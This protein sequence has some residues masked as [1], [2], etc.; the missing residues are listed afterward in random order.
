MKLPTTSIIPVLRVCRGR[1]MCGSGLAAGHRHLQRGA[2]Q[3][4]HGKG[5]ASETRRAF[6]LNVDQMLNDS[7]KNISSSEVEGEAIQPKM[8]T[9]LPYHVSGAAPA[10]GSL[11]PIR[12]VSTT[13]PMAPARSGR[14]ITKAQRDTT[15]PFAPAGPSMFIGRF[16]RSPY[17]REILEQAH[18]RN[19][20]MRGDALKKTIRQA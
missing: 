20:I 5:S 17:A 2:P 9:V 4:A 8:R 7:R 18:N 13:T 1:W 10:P 16:H 14:L 11:S 12:L 19:A 15:R 3:S 6:I